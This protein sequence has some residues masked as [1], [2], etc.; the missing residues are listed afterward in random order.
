[1]FAPS[2]KL[3]YLSEMLRNTAPSFSVLQILLFARAWS[4][5]GPEGA[6]LL[7]PKFYFV[8]CSFT[9][10]IP[11]A[12]ISSSTLPLAGY[13]VQLFSAFSFGTSQPIDSDVR[14]VCH[15]DVRCSAQRPRR[16][17]YTLGNILPMRQAPFPSLWARAG[18]PSGRCLK[19]RRR[20]HPGTD[21]DRGVLCNIAFSGF[22]GTPQLLVYFSPS[23]S[24][25]PDL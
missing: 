15:S 6:A 17:F 11:A 7:I 10:L 3:R 12:F 24:P 22:F 9:A 13:L 25:R 2:S 4:S 14:S 23:L 8:I 1:M 5:F 19:G 18:R 20:A 16:S 21:R